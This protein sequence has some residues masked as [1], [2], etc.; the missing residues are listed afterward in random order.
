MDGILNNSSRH[1]VDPA[2]MVKR[3]YTGPVGIF[4]SIKDTG[5][6]SGVVGDYIVGIQIP[7]N[8]M[9]QATAGS[10]KYV[11]RNFF[12]KTG[13]SVKISAKGSEANDVSASASFTTKGNTMTGMQG[14]VHKIDITYE[15][16]QAVYGFVLLFAP[17]DKIL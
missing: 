15:A 4:G 8:S 6:W 16:G 5:A 13:A 17:I 3:D 7:Y 1:H 11:P 14:A 9:V 12:R 2:E 10:D